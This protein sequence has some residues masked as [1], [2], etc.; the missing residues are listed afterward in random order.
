MLIRLNPALILRLTQ[1]RLSHHIPAHQAC[2]LNG[3]SA[4]K[5]ESRFRIRLRRRSRIEV[6]E[7]SNLRNS[8]YDRQQCERDSTRGTGSN[9]RGSPCCAQ[10]L[11]FPSF[12]PLSLRFPIPPLRLRSFSHTSSVSL[13]R[14]FPLRPPGDSSLD[15]TLA[16]LPEIIERSERDNLRPKHC[17]PLRQTKVSRMRALSRQVSDESHLLQPSFRIF[18]RRRPL[19]LCS[20]SS[21]TVDSA[22]SSCSSDRLVDSWNR[23]HKR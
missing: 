15:R 23:K 8:R 14:Y 21:R 19:L 5:S 10:Y 4:H 16:I 6:G 11:Q 12:R 20:A 7:K 3:D 22:L 9:L 2:K 17:S 18:E 13:D 1:T